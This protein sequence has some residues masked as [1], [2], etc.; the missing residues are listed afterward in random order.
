VQNDQDRVVKWSCAISLEME[1]MM[2]E[3]HTET[4]NKRKQG[5]EFLIKTENE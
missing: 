2:V 5:K 1:L 3:V 4:T